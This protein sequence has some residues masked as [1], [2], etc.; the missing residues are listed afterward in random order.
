[1]RTEPG[2]SWRVAALAA[3]AVL[4]TV[5]LIVAAIF[6]AAGFLVWFV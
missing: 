2:A 4:G 3:F 5:A 6:T 1:M